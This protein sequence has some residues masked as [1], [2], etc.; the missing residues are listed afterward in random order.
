M[1]EVDSLLGALESIKDQ[2][3]I[4]VVLAP[5]S[6]EDELR[7]VVSSKIVINIPGLDTAIAFGMELQLKS[8]STKSYEEARQQAHSTLAAKIKEWPADAVVE[9]LM[10]KEYDQL[11][12]LF[13][14]KR[15]KEA[16]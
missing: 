5:S 3:K 16:N 9:Y 13:R 1:N 7:E 6:Y 4:D 14:K 15:E 12:S 11:R 2:I 8:D 10:T